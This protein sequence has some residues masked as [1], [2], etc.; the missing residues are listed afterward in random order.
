MQRTQPRYLCGLV[1][2]AMFAALASRAAPARA[3]A[4]TF[5]T[6]GAQ[7]S[8]Q[9]D[10][11]EPI[12]C[13]TGSATVHYFVGVTMFEDVQRTKGS[14]TTGLIT[15]IAVGVLNFCTFDFINDFQSFDTGGTLQMNGVAHGTMTGSFVLP[16]TNTAVSFNLSL[17]GVGLQQQGV[18]IQRN[19]MGGGFFSSH[20]NETHRDATFTGS[21]SVNGHSLALANAV[22]TAAGL[23]QNKSGSVTLFQP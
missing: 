15:A 19:T 7:A 12:T 10:L 9:F 16:N 14:V 23:D 13:G 21:V 18:F 22:N 6:K 5:E 2:I 1:A 17:T 20:T 3:A 8:V 11:D 4:S